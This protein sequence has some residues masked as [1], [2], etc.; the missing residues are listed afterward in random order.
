MT[1][2]RY[3]LPGQFYLVTRRCTQRQF[4]LRPDTETNQI[5]EFSLALAAKRTGIGLIAWLAMSNHYH[6]VVYDPDGRIPEFTHYH[7]RLTAHCLNRKWGRAENV[8]STEETCLTLLGSEADVL[9]KVGYVLGNPVAAGLVRRAEDWPGASSWSYMDGKPRRIMRPKGFKK[10]GSVV[11]EE[12]ELRVFQ[13]PSKARRSFA[14]WATSVI[15]EVGD[16]ERRAAEARAETGAAVKGRKVVLAAKPTDTPDTERGPN[17]LRPRVACREKP[18]RYALLQRLKE[19]YILYRAGREDLR[20][21]QRAVFPP[22]TYLA[23]RLGAVV[24]GKRASIPKDVLNKHLS[25]LDRS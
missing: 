4:L 13:P 11:P 15:E 22:G 12:V 16:V 24:I 5:F 10:E 1:A 3:I 19:F 18:M 6:A 9:E 14:A 21:K 8:W 25:R 17:K 20:G 7:H 2:P 23:K